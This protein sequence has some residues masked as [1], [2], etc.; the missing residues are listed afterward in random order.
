M[1]KLSAKIQARIN[2]VMFLYTQSN[3]MYEPDQPNQMY[4]W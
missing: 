3:K 2:Y 1:L 4:G